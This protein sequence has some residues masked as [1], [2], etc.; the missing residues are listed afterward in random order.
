MVGGYTENVTNHRTVEIGGWALAQGW[1]LARD[2]TV[3]ITIISYHILETKNVY[4]MNSMAVC[5][6]L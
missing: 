3:M 2:T 6:L 4:V 5:G 1:A